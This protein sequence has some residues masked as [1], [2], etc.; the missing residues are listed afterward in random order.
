M[1]S[2]NHILRRAVQFVH[3]NYLRYIKQPIVVPSYDLLR[4]LTYSQ[5]QLDAI[6]A[7]PKKVVF[8]R[9]KKRILLLRYIARVGGND[10]Y[11]EDKEIITIPFKARGH[12]VL[13]IYWK[14]EDGRNLSIFSMVRA[15][16]DFQPDIVILS[17]YSIKN[18]KT[19]QPGLWVF[20]RCKKLFPNIRL[21][22]WHWDT[23]SHSFWRDFREEKVVDLHVAIDNSYVNVG[24]VTGINKDIFSKF[25][26]FPMVYSRDG[27]LKFDNKIF[28]VFFSGQIH[29]YRS[30][31]K[32][33]IDALK[34]LGGN[35]VIWTDTIG[36]QRTR[37][38]YVTTLRRSRI[39]INFSLSFD[40]HQLKGRAIEA[41]TCGCLL[42]ETRGGTT[43]DYFVEGEHFQTFSSPD[44]MLCKI[45]Y[46][47]ENHDEAEKIASAANEHMKKHNNAK[48]LVNNCL[49]RLY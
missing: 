47:L 36:S 44:E 8:N 29:S 41:I 46:F 9:A 7:E 28:D 45:Q 5:K 18:K 2:K 3:R 6:I 33:Y 40:M 27:G 30:Y 10:D 19:L 26:F 24:K 37:L 12:N 11:S 22:V 32:D 14:G 23:G 1:L 49:S 48:N 31:R 15:F 20:E 38:E 34:T 17:D 13:E 4:R 35:N 39:A 42:L 21:V 25:L 16:S 43:A